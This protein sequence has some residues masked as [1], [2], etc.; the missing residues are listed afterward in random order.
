MKMIIFHHFL[1]GNS[2]IGNALA[3]GKAVRV[4]AP[5]LIFFYKTKRQAR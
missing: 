3:P 5:D 4:E 2:I 1:F